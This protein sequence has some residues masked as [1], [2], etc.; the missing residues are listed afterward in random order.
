MSP[1]ANITTFDVRLAPDE[2]DSAE[3]LIAR[4]QVMFPAMSIDDAIDFIFR[5]GLLHLHDQAVVALDSAQAASPKGLCISSGQ[6]SSPIAAQG[7]R[8]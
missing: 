7:V 2:L 8:A 6:I 4:L 5:C 1:A 3:T